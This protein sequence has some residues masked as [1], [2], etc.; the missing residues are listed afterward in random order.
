VLHVSTISNTKCCT[1]Y[2]TLTPWC[3]ILFEK[4]I[5]TQLV[6]KSPAFFIESEGSLPCSQ[7]PA[8]GPV[9]RIYFW[10]SFSFQCTQ[11]LFL[12]SLTENFMTESG[13]AIL[14]PGSYPFS[15]CVYGG[16]LKASRQSSMKR[17][18]INAYKISAG[19]RQ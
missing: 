15:C 19:N 9:H 11:R 14:E 2:S 7:N 6:K 8:T 1:P 5:V 18:I 10:V 13:P 3:R 4:L 12:S 16:K 17:K